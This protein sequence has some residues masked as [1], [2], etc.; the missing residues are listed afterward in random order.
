MTDVTCRGYTRVMK[1]LETFMLCALLL[2]VIGGA[3]SMTLFLTGCTLLVLG[4]VL[5]EGYSRR[6]R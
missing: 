6:G 4:L 3:Y 1:R 2:T 5:N